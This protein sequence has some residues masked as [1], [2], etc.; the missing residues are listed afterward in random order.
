MQNGQAN[1][2]ASIVIAHDNVVIGHVTIGCDI[3]SI[4]LGEVNGK[5][6]SLGIIVAP[7]VNA[8]S[9]YMHAL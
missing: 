9:V 4:K 1:H 8:V 6:V 7:E 5:R 3:G 2:L